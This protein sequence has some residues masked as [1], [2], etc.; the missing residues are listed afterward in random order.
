MVASRQIGKALDEDTLI[1]TPNRGF[2]RM[3]DLKDKDKVF[4]KD[5]K[6][7]NVIKAHDTLYDRD[8]FEVEF[9]DGE[10]IIADADHNW[11]VSDFGD[12]L[13]QDY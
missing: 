3:G 8:C 13:S 1:P 5:G 12:E 2:V 9:D 11:S 7:C 4:G 6:I 10:V